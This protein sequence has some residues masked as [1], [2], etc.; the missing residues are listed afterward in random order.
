MH[1][2]QFLNDRQLPFKSNN[3]WKIS[4]CW[5]QNILELS[6][7]YFEPIEGQGKN[8][9]FDKRQLISKGLFFSILP[10]NSDKLTFS[11][12]F[13]GRTLVED[14]YYSEYGI[15]NLMWSTFVLWRVRLDL[16]F[17]C[18]TKVQLKSVSYNLT[19]TVM[20]T[21]MTGQ[22]SLFVLFLGLEPQ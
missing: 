10:R 4:S 9:L 2:M 17:R 11:S 18:D 6:Q 22:D 13:F 20:H 16:N 1:N 3:M 12:S 21:K 8:L 19:L 15:Y 7:T 14:I 5:C